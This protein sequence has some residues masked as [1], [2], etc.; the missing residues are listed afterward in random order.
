MATRRRSVVWAESA[1]RGLD[2]AGGPYRDGSAA[3][4][5]RAAEICSAAGALLVLA[6]GRRRITASVAGGLLC[7]GSLF[8]RFSVFRAGFESAADPSATIRPQRT[9][10][11]SSE[12]SS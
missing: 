3:F 7:A 6:A 12:R 1:R 5:A 4:L 2:D 9:R 11:G 10:M 8:T